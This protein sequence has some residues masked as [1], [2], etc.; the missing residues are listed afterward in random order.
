MTNKIRSMAALI[1]Y[2]FTISACII[3]RKISMSRFVVTYRACPTR[4]IT[5][6]PGSS[7]HANN[8]QPNPEPVLEQI[9]RNRCQCCQLLCT[10]KI[11]ACVTAFVALQP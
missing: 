5:K 2:T 7:V 3:D 10:L 11:F 4:T 1:S 8:L 6:G 9:E